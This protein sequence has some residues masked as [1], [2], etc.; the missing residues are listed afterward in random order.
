MRSTTYMFEFSKSGRILAY[1]S[2][3]DK[4]QACERTR[5]VTHLVCIPTGCK[6]RVVAEAIL[7][8]APIFFEQHLHAMENIFKEALAEA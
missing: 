1:I 5:H 4:T 3:K 2:A 6:V 8:R 7:G